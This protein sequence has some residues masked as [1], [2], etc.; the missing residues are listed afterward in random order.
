MPQDSSLYLPILVGAV[1]NWSPE[2]N[3]QRDDEG[4]NISSKNPFFNELTAIYWAWKNLN[5]AEY[6]GLVQYRR[7]FINKDKS[8]E[9]VKYLV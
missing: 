6:I 7:V 3:Y 8:I 9:S 5:D 4:E 2:V 1:N